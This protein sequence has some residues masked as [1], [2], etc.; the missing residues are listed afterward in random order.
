[1][2]KIVV[3]DLMTHPVVTVSPATPFK[4]L[5]AILTEYKIG[6]VPVLDGHGHPIGVVSESD[7]LAKEEQRGGAGN[8]PSLLSSP[9][10]WRRWGKGRGTTAGDVMTRRV[11]TVSRS[12]PIAVAAQKMLREGLRRLYVV[13]GSGRLAGVLARRDVLHVFLRP[14]EELREEIERTVLQRCLWADPARTSVRVRDGEVTLT[15]E[16]EL[17]SEGRRAVR[18]IEAIPGVVAVYDELRFAVDD[19]VRT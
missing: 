16:V 10:R 19:V 12:E 4:N 3:A 5:V 8:P 13:D 2:N 17:R 7:L 18:L 1:M 11:R 15:G 14:D 9:R 6:S